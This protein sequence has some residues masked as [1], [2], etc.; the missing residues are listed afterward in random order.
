EIVPVIPISVRIIRL[1]KA[2]IIAKVIA[3]PA[4]S[5]SLKMTHS[6]VLI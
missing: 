1:V 6:E 4:L 5:P 3:I 2:E